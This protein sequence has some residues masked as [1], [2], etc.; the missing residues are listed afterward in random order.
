[1]LIAA[2]GSG[3]TQPLVVIAGLVVFMGLALLVAWLLPRILQV[4][5]SEKDLFLIVSVASGLAIAGAGALVF[6][7]PM[8]LTAFIAG[9]P[10]SESDH[11]QEAGGLLLPFRVL[12]AVLFFVA[13]GT[14][15][16]PG[17]IAVAWCWLLALL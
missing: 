15:I 4:L 1:V 17:Q 3:A 10:I 2:M 5:H 9:L 16:D 12:L 13:I 11:P 6:H 14:L 8:A 7:V